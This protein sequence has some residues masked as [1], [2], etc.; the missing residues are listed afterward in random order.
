MSELVIR[1]AR[2]DDTERLAQF[3]CAMALETERKALDPATVA[4]G[5]RA[6]L[7]DPAKGF[8]LVAERG[9][10]VVG[11]LLVTFEWSDWRDGTIY[12]LQSVY[13]SPEAR[14]HGVYRA[15]HEH[16]VREA[17]ADG[18]VRA[19]RLYVEADNVRAQATYQALGM[20]RSQYVMFELGVAGDG[21]GPRAS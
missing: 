5:C 18:S 3:N 12:W 7:E 19:I 14:R 10:D 13:V 21:A 9:G 17:R 15:L 11:Q 1:R 2:A 16:V 6:V 8:Y 20:E 4:A